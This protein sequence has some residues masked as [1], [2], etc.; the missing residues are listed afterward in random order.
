MAKGA[1]ASAN[2][3][4]TVKKGLQTPTKLNASVGTKTKKVT[5]ARGTRVNIRRIDAN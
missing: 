2:S 3:G 5:T 4:K 1:K